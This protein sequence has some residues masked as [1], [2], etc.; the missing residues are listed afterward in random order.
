MDSMMADGIHMMEKGK[1]TTVRD[2]DAI[3]M[4]KI[5]VRIHPRPTEISQHLGQFYARLAAFLEHA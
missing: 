4:R 2:R 5:T 3:V 1:L